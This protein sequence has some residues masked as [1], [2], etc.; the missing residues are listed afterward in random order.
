MPVSEFHLNSPMVR[1]I[2]I[3]VV[4]DHQMI[5]E[6]IVASLHDIFYT[7][8]VREAANNREALQKLS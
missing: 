4:D 8:V 1:I 7:Q 3:L 5:R 6:G 2:N